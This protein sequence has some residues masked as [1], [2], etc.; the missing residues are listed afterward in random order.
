[1]ANPAFQLAGKIP[2]K[3][4]QAWSAALLAGTLASPC[5]IPF[6]YYFFFPLFLPDFNVPILDLHHSTGDGSQE[7]AALQALSQTMQDIA[8]GTLECKCMVCTHTYTI[9]WA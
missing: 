2:D 3:R 4:L 8:T 1:M 5:L 6:P 7:H 9:M